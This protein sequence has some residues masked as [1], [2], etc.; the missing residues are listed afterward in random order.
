M[1]YGEGPGS[2]KQHHFVKKG[3]GYELWIWNSDKYCGKILH[4][5]SGKR[6]SWHYHIEKDEVFYV[7]S[8][9]VRLLYGYNPD[10]EK[11]VELILGPDSSFHIPSR[12]NHQ[13]IALEDSDVIEFS[14]THRDEDSIRL[15]KGD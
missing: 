2:D 4:L 6:F 13:L 5:D 3:W 11:A 12:L 10:I 1:H 7:R 14:T 15:I 9:R 8:G